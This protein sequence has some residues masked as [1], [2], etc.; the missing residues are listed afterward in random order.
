[1][2]IDV[3][4]EIVIHRS[5]EDVADFVTNSDNDSIWIGGIVEAK[6]VTAPPLA[7]GTKVARVATFLGRR[8][9]YGPE[10]VEYSPNSLL[11]MHT[12]S[13][14]PMRIRYKFEEA[15]GGT[16][17]RIHIQGG[18][19]GFY[20]LASPLLAR[21]VKRNISSDL[22]TLKELLESEADTS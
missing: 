2:S 10:V 14:F 12:D 9:E 7:V 22:E 20:R 4:A 17:A 13:P 18:G 19:T 11:T 21:V 3:K 16:L 6:M 15:I 8:M 1:M 5:R